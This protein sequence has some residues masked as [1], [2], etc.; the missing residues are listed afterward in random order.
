VTT[1]PRR[2]GQAPLWARLVADPGYAPEHVAVEA[3]RRL[4]PEARAWVTR[5]RTRYPGA[6]PDGLARIAA[7]E[8]TRLA[9]R[10]GAAAGTVG[11]LATIGVLAHAQSRL[12]LTIAAAYGYDPTSEARARDLVRILRVPRFT[13]PTVAALAD[14]GRLVAGYAARVLVNRLVPFGASLVGVVQAGRDS[15][16]VTARAVRFYRARTAGRAP[17]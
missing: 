4:G 13:Q 17:L 16:D 11:A 8:Y 2:T 1:S 10:R 3:V 12:V 5:L 7:H 6:S 14:S 9:R 15:A